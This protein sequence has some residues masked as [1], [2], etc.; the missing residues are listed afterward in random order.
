MR[1]ILG[2]G[3]SLCLRENLHILNDFTSRTCLTRVSKTT[4]SASGCDA[5]ACDVTRTTRKET[6][7]LNLRWTSTFFSPLLLLLLFHVNCNFSFTNCA[8]VSMSVCVDSPGCDPF[9][10]CPYPKATVVFAQQHF[11]D[12][13]N[14]IEG[15]AYKFH[16][17]FLQQDSKLFLS[18]P[19]AA[20]LTS[21]IEDQFAH[22]VTYIHCVVE[23]VNSHGRQLGFLDT[24]AQTCR[25]RIISLHGKVSLFPLNVRDY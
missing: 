12:F 4:L 11:L 7:F 6:C 1:I 9:S 15:S 23:G 19:P 17:Y 25:A 20:K 22:C 8:C 18:A 3:T 10:L 16:Q 14:R 2:Y 13:S 24:F 5:S 21:L